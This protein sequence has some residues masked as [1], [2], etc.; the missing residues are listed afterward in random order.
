M[1]REEQKARREEEILLA[2]LDLFTKKGYAATKTSEISK[3]LGISEGL[4]FHYFKS[5]EVLLEA[6][7]D[8]AMKENISWLEQ[9][10]KDPIQY[11]ADIAK[12]VLRCLKDND[13]GSKFFVL[14]AQIKLYEDIPEHI[15]KKVTAQEVQVERIINI[16]KK[17]QE[18]GQIKQGDPQALLYL[19]SDTLQ[20]VA[21][22][23]AR[24]KN[25]PYPDAE[26]IVDI[27]KNHAE[28]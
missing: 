7:V 9:N 23:A 4:L 16:V 3:A 13:V 28:H 21:M 15:R 25:L 6:L 1:K 22:G 10:C 11:F 2:A 12:A 14:I 17:G 5:K 18:M 27:L 26:W 20:A 19:F 8:F 24:H